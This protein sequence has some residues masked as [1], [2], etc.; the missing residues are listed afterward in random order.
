MALSTSARVARRRLV[1]TSITTFRGIGK[2]YHALIEETGVDGRSFAAKFDSRM[3]AET[4]VLRTARKHFPVRTHKL[5]QSNRN[6]PWFYRE[7][8]DS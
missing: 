7:G 3:Q 2:H 6:G 1:H 4:W 8:R 5:L